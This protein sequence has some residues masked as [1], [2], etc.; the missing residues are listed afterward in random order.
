MTLPD[1]Y[2]PFDTAKIDVW[3]WS[4]VDI[5]EEA[6]G[7]T[8]EADLIQYKVIEDLKAATLYDVIYDDGLGE[9]ADVVGIKVTEED[10]E[11]VKT[12]G[13]SKLNQRTETG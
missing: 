10:S 13:S 2:V 6:Q 5:K 12:H 4:P 11:C 3:D 8:R 9:S 1:A 7:A